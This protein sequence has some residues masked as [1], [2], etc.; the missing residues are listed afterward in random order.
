MKQIF[1]LLII[2]SCGVYSAEKWPYLTSGAFKKARQERVAKMVQSCDTIVEIGGA[3]AP[4]SGFVDRN[5]KVIVI[6]PEIRRKEED[7][8]T[9]LR[10]GFEKWNEWPVSKNYAVVILGLQLEMPDGAWKK[11]HDLIDRSAITVIEYSAHNKEAKKQFRDI[12]ASVN[13]EWA[14][15]E[16]LEINGAELAKYKGY[17]F[18][19]RILQCAIAKKEQNEQQ[20]GEQE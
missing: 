9:H 3:G 15:P 19:H 14:E 20:N 13:K 2:F 1:F 16:E 8:I 11:L 12:R 4:M 18:N 17:V 10:M 7:N 6:D 5:K